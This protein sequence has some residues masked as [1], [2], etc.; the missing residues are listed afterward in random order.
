[1]K[2]GFQSIMVKL[3]D[4]IAMNYGNII[5]EIIE[6]LEELNN[7]RIVGHTTEASIISYNGETVDLNELILFIQTH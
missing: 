6:D 2:L 5:L 1:M 4:L 3:D 7:V